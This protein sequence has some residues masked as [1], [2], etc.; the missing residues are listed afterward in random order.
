MTIHTYCVNTYMSHY[1]ISQHISQD[2]VRALV[3][4]S[5][6]LAQVAG[7]VGC[8]FQSSPPKIDQFSRMNSSVYWY[9]VRS[10]N[11]RCT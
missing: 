1:Y 2:I 10:T 6:I 11:I 3:S 7:A 4:E 9:G 5:S 8:W